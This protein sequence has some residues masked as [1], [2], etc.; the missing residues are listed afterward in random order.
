MALL[1]Y[2]CTDFCRQ[3]YKKSDIFLFKM[4]FFAAIGYFIEFFIGDFL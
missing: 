2:F 3:A 4:I 1:K